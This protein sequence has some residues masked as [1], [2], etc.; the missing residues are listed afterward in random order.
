MK[1]LKIRVLQVSVALLLAFAFVSVYAK[2][3]AVGQSIQLQAKK[4][5]GV[6]LHKEAKSSMMGR[7][8]HGT[9]ATVLKIQKNW[10][11]IK[12]EDGKT[13]WIVKKYIA[14]GKLAAAPKDKAKAKPKAEPKKK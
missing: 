5:Q 11:Q 9:K 14:K 3:I 4:K 6:P 2:G 13:A 10:Y 12:T 1:A 7:A 8:K